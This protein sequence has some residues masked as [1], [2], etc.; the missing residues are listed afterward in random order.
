MDS[1]TIKR[2]IAD[3]EILGALQ[4]GPHPGSHQDNLM[5]LGADFL[6]ASSP[7]QPVPGD[8]K[9]KVLERVDSTPARVTTDIEGR[10]TSINPAFSGMCGF[11]FAEIRGRKPGSL[12]QGEKTDPR[13]VEVIREAVRQRMPC[14]SEM[15]N[16]HKDGSAYQVHIE[17]EPL[18]DETGEVVGFQAT[19]TKL[20]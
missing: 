4:T 19:E 5:E 15:I 11:S 8:L 17:I 14:V 7:R 6:L 1:E 18:R 10:V 12:L 16:Y 2:M 20:V 13:S 9:A 3:L